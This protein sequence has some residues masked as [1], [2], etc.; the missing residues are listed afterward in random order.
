[1]WRILGQYVIVHNLFQNTEVKSDVP[2]VWYFEMYN[3]R[4]RERES[5]WVWVYV[6]KQ[7]SKHPN[8]IWAIYTVLGKV[9]LM[10]FYFF[11][12]RNVGD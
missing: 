10:E 12:L 11:G 2:T 6:G 9:Q 3:N 1:M 4:G 7:P 8:C 5:V